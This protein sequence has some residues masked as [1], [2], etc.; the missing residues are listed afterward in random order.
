MTEMLIFFFTGNVKLTRRCD[1]GGVGQED[2]RGRWQGGRVGTATFICE[3][4][5]KVGNLC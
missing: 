5:G 4:S 3:Q 1:G 2:E